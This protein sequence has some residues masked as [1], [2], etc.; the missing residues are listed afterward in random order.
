[1][2]DGRGCTTHLIF[3]LALH[4][5]LNLLGLR[6]FLLR[7]RHFEHAVLHRGMDL[8]RLHD[9]G[10]GEEAGEGAIRTLDPIAVLLLP[11]IPEFPLSADREANSLVTLPLMHALVSDTVVSDTNYATGRTGRRNNI[12]LPQ[13]KNYATFSAGGR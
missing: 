9:R 2:F 3:N 8:A 11:F 5:N 7:D 6:F 4:F 1:M 13:Q 10:Q 12:F